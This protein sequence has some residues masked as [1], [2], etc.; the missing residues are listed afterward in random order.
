[1]IL[2]AEYVSE[3]NVIRKKNNGCIIASVMMLLL[4]FGFMLY[5]MIDFRNKT[6]KEWD[7]F[8]DE[9]IAAIENYLYMTMPEGAEPVK[10]KRDV[11]P[12]DSCTR[13]IVGGISDPQEFMEKAFPG[14]EIKELAPDEELNKALNESISENKEVDILKKVPTDNKSFG[15]IKY[16]L[17]ETASMLGYSIEITEIYSRIRD[18]HTMDRYYIGFGKADDGY[19]ADIYFL[20]F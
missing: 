9:R 12:G 17:D 18:E 2:M 11:G 6:H 13:L 16:E 10:F 8:D 19:Y 5:A 1:M 3:K 4:F 14:V 7:T 20:V 15:S